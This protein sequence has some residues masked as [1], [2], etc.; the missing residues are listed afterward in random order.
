MK[1]KYL[2]ILCLLSA[3]MFLFASCSQYDDMG[4]GDTTG[5]GGKP[6]DEKVESV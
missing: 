1:I 6:N 2:I 4:N 3:I 5:G